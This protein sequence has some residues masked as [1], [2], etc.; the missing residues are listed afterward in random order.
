M[1]Q[2]VMAIL[3]TLTVISSSITVVLIWG[4]S[5]KAETIIR[6]KK[7]TGTADSILYS[8]PSLDSAIAQLKK[9]KETLDSL[10]GGKT[11]YSSL[12]MTGDVL[13]MFKE[14]MITIFSYRL[15]GKSTDKELAV[16]AEGNMEDILKLIYDLSF[17][18]KEFH[19]SFISVDTRKAGKPASLVLRI[20]HG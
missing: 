5:R 15:E 13:R 4:N 2:R 19:I 16:I 8:I 11:A 6:E 10:A 18:N 12:T 1:K 14:H 7:K 3:F 17:T 20:A 9:E